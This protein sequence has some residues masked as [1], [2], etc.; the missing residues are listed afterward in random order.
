MTERPSPLCV[1]V[2]RAMDQRSRPAFQASVS[3]HDAFL[4]WR[5]QQTPGHEGPSS[6]KV[7]EQRVFALKWQQKELK[8]DTQKNFPVW[9]L[10]AE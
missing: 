9:Y 7:A 2:G 8:Q 6:P 4:G 5:T 3:N 1:C 10:G